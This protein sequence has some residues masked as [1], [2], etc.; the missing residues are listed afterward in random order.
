MARESLTSRGGTE[1]WYL[2]RALRRRGLETMVVIRPTP[3]TD[4]PSRS[5]AGV[6]LPGNAGH[7]IAILENDG[8]RIKIADPLFGEFT[9]SK[10]EMLNQYHFTGFF[11]VL[12]GHT[13]NM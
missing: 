11:L 7:F 12:R 10:Q 6:V 9:G 1:I 13:R 2:A 3:V 4:I 5:I 8:E